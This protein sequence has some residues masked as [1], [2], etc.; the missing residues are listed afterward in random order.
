MRIIYRVCPFKPDNVPL[1]HS[2]DKWK[3]VEMCHNSFLKAGAS[4]YPITYIIDSVDWGKIFM[5]WGEIVEINTHNK[6]ASLKTAYEV[7]SKMDDD[8]LFVEDDYLWRPDTVP[9]IELA[10]KHLPVL[11]PYDHPG[12]YTEDRFDHKYEIKLIGNQTYRTC[13]SNTH[14]FSIQNKVFHDNYDM[15]YKFGVEDHAMFTELNKV[16]Q[17]WCP[18]PTFATHLA[19]GCISPNVD[20]KQFT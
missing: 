1:F 10:L 13:P 18:M 11:S 6:V 17:L 14:T 2:D 19:T 12:H 8:I 7:A 20:W 16:A 15:M 3:L 9:L 5:R 4:Q